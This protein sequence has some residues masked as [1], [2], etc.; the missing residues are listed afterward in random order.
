VRSRRGRRQALPVHTALFSA[1]LLSWVGWRSA[2][3]SRLPKRPKQARIPRLLFCKFCLRPRFTFA[4]VASSE[5]VGAYTRVAGVS[6]R[7]F[8]ERGVEGL[9]VALAALLRG[10]LLSAAVSCRWG[11][12]RLACPRV[13]LPLQVREESAV[14]TAM[15]G[16]LRGP[17][18]PAC[19][20]QLGGETRSRVDPAVLKIR[21]RIGTA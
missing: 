5:R 14:R 16:K 17:V 19:A 8:D 13:S 15:L 7:A 9:T 21:H 10:L 4:G 1:A 20:G 2:L 3:H 11:R 18:S 6:F 12:A